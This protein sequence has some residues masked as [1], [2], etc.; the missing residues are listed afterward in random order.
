LFK[1][2]KPSIIVET[3]TD[4]TQAQINIIQD[5]ELDEFLN[6]C[7]VPFVKK[8]LSDKLNHL[9]K[10]RSEDSK[11]KH[12]FKL[13]LKLISSLDNILFTEGWVYM[14]EVK[15]GIERDYAVTL[16]S[17]E[18]KKKLVNAGFSVYKGGA[19]SKLVVSK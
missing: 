16:S 6:D 12:P 1:K 15:L 2:E 17:Q 10:S 7:F 4:M 11:E 8:W 9:E 13:P 5:K 18:L 3:L 19:L 14:Q